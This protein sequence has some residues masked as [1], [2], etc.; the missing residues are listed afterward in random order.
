M[1]NPI[2]L[3]QASISGSVINAVAA[4]DLYLGLGLSKDQ[5]S[6]WSMLNIQR[7]KFFF[8]D[9]D[10]IKLDIMSS[11]ETPNS[12]VDY[13]L[14]IEMAKHL[15][16]QA[17][18]EKSHEYRTYFI[19]LE[20]NAVSLINSTAIPVGLPDFNN[21][22]ESARAW[23]DVKESEQKQLAIVDAQQKSIARKDQYIIASNEASIKSGE[24]TVSEFCKAN[25]LVDIGRNE[26]YEWMRGQGYVFKNSCEP[27]QE[28]VNRGFFTWKPSADPIN[29]EFRYTLRITPRGA[30]WLA[31]KYMAFLDAEIIV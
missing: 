28:F 20:R 27:K 7:N 6:R 10:F 30:V 23:A 2:K 12:P 13:A 9:I 4:R 26:F 21:P 3:I 31:A 19:E 25:D 14:S 5:W 15:A 29:G 11:V 1:K 24:I 22:I 8:E 16:M 18:T 17:A